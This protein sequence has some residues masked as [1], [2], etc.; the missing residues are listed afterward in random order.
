M[1]LQF[2]GFSSSPFSDTPDVRLFWEAHCSQVI[3]KSLLQG[4]IDH[5]RLQV[6]IA[7]PG[8]GKSVLCRRL[9]NSLRSHRS[10]YDVLYM[11]F[12]NLTTTELLNSA[13][14]PAAPERRK[15]LI[16]DEAQAL[17]D[18]SLLEFIKLLQQDSTGPELQMVF[19]AQPELDQRL[20]T[21]CF[22]I[23]ESLSF[24]RYGL[25]PL[26]A[27]QTAAYINNRLMLTG[28]T[29]E[30][31]MN[32]EIAGLAFRLTGGVPR[33]INT[34]MRKSLLLAFEEQSRMLT[35]EHLKQA[36]STTAA[37]VPDSVY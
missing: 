18:R 9:L 27:D 23:T 4:L 11:A 8:L 16:I 34:L 10:R 17:S 19:F 22:E 25:L 20:T 7:E 3:F 32:P 24:Q 13:M 31:L 21:L 5:R 1:Y 15:V 26:T 36:A 37:S 30:T 12:P 28:I 33:L 6:V 2:F 35:A 14:S 29:P